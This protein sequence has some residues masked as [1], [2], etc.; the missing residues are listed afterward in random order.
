MALDFGIIVKRKYIVSN[1]LIYYSNIYKTGSYLHF[2]RLSLFP[3]VLLIL[4]RYTE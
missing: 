2:L 3:W 4:R 1:T